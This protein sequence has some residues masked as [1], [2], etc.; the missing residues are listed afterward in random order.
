VVCLVGLQGFRAAR[1]PRATAGPLAGGLGGRPA[2][3]L[4]S[5]SGRNASA[6][7]ASLAAHFRAAAA[8]L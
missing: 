7:V 3:L 4:P 8:M 5:T 6:T 1:D 2:W